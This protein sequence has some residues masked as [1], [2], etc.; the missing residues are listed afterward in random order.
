M[1]HMNNQS[2]SHTFCEDLGSITKPT[3]TLLKACL[4]S[5]SDER[6][7]S[8]M[9]GHVVIKDFASVG[10]FLWG[11]FMQMFGG[12]FHAYALHRLILY[13][14]TLGLE[15]VTSWSVLQL[16]ASIN[17]VTSTRSTKTLWQRT[18]GGRMG[19]KHCCMKGRKFITSTTNTTLQKTRH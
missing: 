13:G 14:Q 2:M 1:T 9:S 3:L 11:C 6:T 16:H 5:D 12:H 15:K 19:E 10:G 7:Y 8:I 4:Y 17:G 18:A